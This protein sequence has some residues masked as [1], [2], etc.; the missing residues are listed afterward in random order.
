MKKT[1]EFHAR[2]NHQEFDQQIQQLQQK[3]KNSQFSDA[4]RNAITSNIQQK[5]AQS[6]IST[7]TTNTQVEQQQK[8]ALRELD[9]FIKEQYKQATM[10][11][12]AIDERARKI[13]Q[14]RKMEKE[15]LNDETKKL[16]IQK[17]MN[18]L[19]NQ[20]QTL[21]KQHMQHMQTVNE[22]V[23]QRNNIRA[24]SVS[25]QSAPLEGLDRLTNA[26]R[27]GGIRGAGRAFTRMSGGLGS[28]GMG[29]LSVA[30]TGVAMADPLIRS[31]AADQ[32][33]YTF[34]QGSAIG[35]ISNTGDIYN[36][37]LASTMYY[38]SERSAALKTSLDKL[39]KT[40]FADS[41]TSPLASVAGIAGKTALGFGIGTAVPVIGNTL[42]A[43][44]G[45][46][47]GVY[48]V[49][50][51]PRSR[52]AM[53]A[54]FGHKGS[55]QKLE[56][57]QYSEFVSDFNSTLEAEK[58]K[59]PV[60]RMAE[61][62]YQATRERNLQVQRSMGM[63]DFDMYG[64]G[65][66]LQSGYGM[67]F[68]EEDT[69]GAA[70]GIL[71]AGGSTRSATANNVLA[72]QLSKRMNLTNSSQV[73]GGIS[74][75]LGGGVETENATI[76][77]LAEGMRL[78]LDKSEF[79]AEQ[80]K[81]A[82]MTVSAI[83]SSGAMSVTGAAEAA[84]SFAAFGGN[85]TM[86]G[87]QGMQA[88]QGFFDSATSSTGNPRGAIFASKIMS[89]PELKGL[90]FDT[91]KTLSELPDS[92]ITSDSPFIKNAAEE[93]GK[94]PE[95][96]VKILKGVKADSVLI[97]SGS[98]KLRSKVQ[99]KYSDMKASGM[100]EEEIT[101]SLQGDKDMNKLLTSLGTEDSNFV[102]LDNAGK[103][104]VGMKLARQD[105]SSD[106]YEEM[107]RAKA[108]S[109][110]P[111]GRVGDASNEAIAKQQEI[112][113]NNFLKMKD[114]LNDAAEAAKNMTE[115]ALSMHIRFAELL[116]K[117]EKITPEDAR[118]ALDFFRKPNATKENP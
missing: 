101:T 92:Q 70:Q 46:A 49:A 100:S 47:K 87:L 75:N 29:A 86:A 45:F 26:Y 84:A 80:R 9:R 105:M 34:A 77:V 20:K 55:R 93:A 69:I 50:A 36:N 58:N 51:D 38:G 30:G 116:A 2:L 115:R 24:N 23:N 63:S 10:L 13:D 71:G 64:T 3:L 94:T 14:L 85:N 111:T 112:V 88:A 108:S 66:M 18:Q 78:G 15:S 11:N 43:V 22:S 113:N 54:A 16:E 72:N 41:Y 91:Q 65:G 59:D 5:L 21:Q 114:A 109:T 35:G 56:G 68:R 4:N 25:P 48:D 102:G 27:T 104:S 79:A 103:Y 96:I 57:M 7:G 67:G 12:K 73:I 81:F 76:K 99:K 32:R 82:E 6:G 33:N 52:Y 28:L 90:S 42:G 31:M 97:R 39:G 44:G 62:R 40:Q 74:R 17:Q 106:D 8:N 107:A 60:K 61:E 37:N 118:K 98:E 89:N 83:Q 110:D 1:I 117:G 95:E 19:E 53:G